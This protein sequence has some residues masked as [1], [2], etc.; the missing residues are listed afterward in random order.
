MAITLFKIDKKK[1]HCHPKPLLSDINVHAKFEENRSK[2]TQ[3]KSPE[4][5]LWQTD[6]HS[7]GLE[8]YKKTVIY[9][10]ILTGKNV[11]IHV[12]AAVA[13]SIT[14]LPCITGSMVWFLF[15][16]LLEWD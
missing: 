14:L 15:L 11:N 9:R 13:Q 12:G 7:N 3:V 8:G 2:T 1:A 10:R 16:K 4:T 5:K 6:G